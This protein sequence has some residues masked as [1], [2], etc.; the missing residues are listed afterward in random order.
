MATS[1]LASG[2]DT[3][4]TVVGDVQHFVVNTNVNVIY[5][6]F[7]LILVLLVLGVIPATKKFAGYAAWTILLVLLVQRKS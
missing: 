7:S 4:S 2:L 6:A 5:K 3:A 1:G